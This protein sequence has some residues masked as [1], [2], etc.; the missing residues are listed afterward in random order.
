[1]KVGRAQHDGVAEPFL[2]LLQPNLAH[3][4][5]LLASRFDQQGFQV[6][7]FP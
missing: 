6:N 5:V 1:M 2:N 7:A 3:A 4:P